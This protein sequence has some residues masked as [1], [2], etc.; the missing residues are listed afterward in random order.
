VGPEQLS[1][2]LTVKASKLGLLLLILAF[3]AAVETAWQLRGKVD[4]GPT[5]CRVLRGRFYG[6]SF[7]FEA[8]KKVE[9]S[10][11]GEQAK[12]EISNAFGSVKVV[13][14]EAGTVSVALKKVVFLPTEAEA[15][16]FA[17]KIQIEASTGDGAL[18]I[19]TNREALARDSEPTGFETHLEVSAPPRTILRVRNNHGA[20]D[21]AGAAEVDVDSSFEDVRIERVAGNVVARANHGNVRIDQVGGELTIRSRH[22]DVQISGVDGPVE[23]VHAHGDVSAERVAGLR[24]EVKNGNVTASEVRGGFLFRGSRAQV[25]ASAVA[26]SAEVETSFGAVRLRDVKADATVKVEH[27]EV[28][29]RDVGGAARVSTSYDQAVLQGI[30]GRADVRVSHGGV[31]ASL[32]RGGAKVEAS[33]DEVEIDGFAG[34]LEV[35][36]SRCG[37]VRLI[38]SG[39]LADAVSVVSRGGDIELTVTP[40]SRF[41]LDAKSSTGEV[42]AEVPGLEATVRESR[43]IEGRVGSGGAVVKLR[44]EHGDVTLVASSDPR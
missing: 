18:R 38:P 9:V 34:P 6:P 11:L 43:R 14:G 33:G 27:G 5:G 2:V 17:D 3:G 24:L 15:R 31:R 36:A 23:V 25:E 35:E 44:A 21:V 1:E 13:E 12:V 8:A 20:V 37:R 42:H 19:G 22:G 32:L 16:V 28:D 4:I 39:A 41:A 30:S 26:E 29:V 40:D 7:R 10:S